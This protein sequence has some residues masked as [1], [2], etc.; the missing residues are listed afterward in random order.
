MLLRALGNKCTSTCQ[1]FRPLCMALKHYEVNNTAQTAEI[2]RRSYGETK[3]DGI[4]RFAP[5]A[6]AEG[7]ECFVVQADL[8]ERLKTETFY[9]TVKGNYPE[10]RVTTGWWMP[11]WTED[12]IFPGNELLTDN[13]DGTWTLT[14]NL[15]GSEM[16]SMLD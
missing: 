8:W 13:G 7:N 10:I 14:V 16:L 3:W 9:V 4:Y 5:E 12:D 11:S 6:T 1:K 2:V 15:S